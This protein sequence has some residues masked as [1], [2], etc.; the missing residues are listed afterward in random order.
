[1]KSTKFAAGAALLALSSPAL[2]DHM[3]PSAFGSGGGMAVFT[4]DTLDEGHWSASLRLSFT[5][6]E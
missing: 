6:P 2:A 1:M 4:P 3:G 5:R